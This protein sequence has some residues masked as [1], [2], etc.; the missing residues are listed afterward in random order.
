M[1]MAD[2]VAYLKRKGIKG[3]NKFKVYYAI[4]M[5]YVQKP[6]KDGAGNYEFAAY[7]KQYEEYFM[8][9]QLKK[10]SK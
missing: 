9:Q 1:V 5:G 10:G 4:E 3:V 7:V 6:L 2:L 8:A